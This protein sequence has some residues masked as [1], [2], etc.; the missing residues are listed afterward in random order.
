M[1][2]KAGEL[3]ILLHY[4]I[5]PEAYPDSPFHRATVAKFVKRGYVD[6]P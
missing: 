4:H 3:H 5:F 6:S 1:T 2:W